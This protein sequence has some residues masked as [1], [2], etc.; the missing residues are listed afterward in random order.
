MA[1][2]Q[3][4]IPWEEKNY[5]YIDFYRK[6]Y[7]NETDDQSLILWQKINLYIDCKKVRLDGI[8]MLVQLDKST[9]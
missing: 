2:K 8:S 6:A 1:Q 9:I 4:M 7:E 5:S 3:M